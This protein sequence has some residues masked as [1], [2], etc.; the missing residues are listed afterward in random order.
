M[1]TEEA[2]EEIWEMFRETDRRFKETDRKFAET[3]RTLEETE[4]LVQERGIKVYEVY[5]DLSARR[6]GIAAQVD[7]LVKDEDLCVVVEAK[8]S[9]SSEDVDKHVERM[10]KFKSLF[11]GY[12]EARVLGAI[13]A[14]VL[15][16]DVA[17]YAY[18]RGFFV[19]TQ[20]GEDVVILN[21]E[22][23]TPAEW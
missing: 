10:N 8:S 9:L 22:D 6:N 23:F 7:L 15:P 17:R 5:H 20:K 3:E 11:R 18:R 2:I 13:A 16:D 21:D 19:I 1:S 12:D 14:I 4:R